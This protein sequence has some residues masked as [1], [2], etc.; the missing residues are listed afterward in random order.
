[1]TGIL[2]GQTAKGANVELDLQELVTGRTFLCAIS[3][4]GKSHTARRVIEQ[5]FG[6]AGLIILDVEGEYASLREKFPF[7]IIGKDVPLVPEAAEFLAD[8]VLANELSAIIDGSD[9]NLDDATF[10]EFIQRFLDRFMALET[11]KRKPYLVVAEEADELAPEHNFARSICG[12]AIKKLAKKG[13]KRGVGIMVVT[14][15]PPS[16][17]KGIISQCS[18]KAIGQLDWDPD[19]EV[20]HKFARIPKDVTAKLDTFKRGDFYVSGPFV[21][22][23]GIVHVGGIVTKHVGETPEVVPPAP[24][25]LADIVSQLGEKLPA[26][27]QEKLVPQVPKVAEI[28]ARLKEKYEAQWNARVVRVQKER[29]AVKRRTEAKYEVEVA[30]LKRKLEDAVRHATMKGG[31]SDLLSHPLVQNNVRGKLNEKQWAFL[32]LLETKGPQ[33]PEHCSLFLETKPD[34]VRGFVYKVNQEVPGLIESQGGRYVSR[35]AKLFPVTEEAQAEAKE[36]EQL[37]ARIATLEEAI[38]N[39]QAIENDLSAQLN[40]ARKERD[41][42]L[43]DLVSMAPDAV[44]HENAAGKK[45]MTPQDEDPRLTS[46]GETPAAATTIPVEATLRRTLTKFTV[47]T[48]TEILDVDESTVTGKLLATG[49]RGFFS[50][51]RGF[52]AIMNELERKYSMNRTSGGSRDAVRQ[53]LEEVVAKDILD[54]R[55]EN[56]QWV[57]SATEHF[58]ERVRKGP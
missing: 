34:S 10:Q 53:S 41:E 56:N 49:L 26:I 36:T 12:P 22:K 35:L 45:R 19:K 7:L 40:Q 14:Q 13:R 38:A 51:G 44:Q 31:V 11:M 5:V 57:Y 28:E 39:H 24:K 6:R 50:E 3:G 2:L 47:A 32:V 42:A 37:R 1:M 55:S 46:A 30:D 18:N 54:R 4:A 8:Q 27:I 16:V 21:A 20:V 58:A 48:N 29:D 17:E 9:P 43:S 33:D 25:E 23:P 15:R 52:G